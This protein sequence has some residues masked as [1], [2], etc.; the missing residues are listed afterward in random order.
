MN[1][2]SDNLVKQKQAPASTQALAGVPSILWFYLIIALKAAVGL[3]Q[4][5]RYYLA[6]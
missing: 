4:Q 6:K 1:I 5:Y 3:V 2:P